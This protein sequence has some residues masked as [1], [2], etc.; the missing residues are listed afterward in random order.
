M[1]TGSLP[2]LSSYFTYVASP[3]P[4][5]FLSWVCFTDGETEA[6]KD[7]RTRSG[8]Y[9]ATGFRHTHLSDILSSYSI[10]ASKPS[11][12]WG[13]QS[14]LMKLYKQTQGFC[15][16]MHWKLTCVGPLRWR[17]EHSSLSLTWPWPPSQDKLRWNSKHAELWVHT[18]EFCATVNYWIFYKYH[19]AWK[20]LFSVW[21]ANACLLYLLKQSSCFN[22]KGS[23]KINDLNII[24]FDIAWDPFSFQEN[25][26]RQQGKSK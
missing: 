9:S 16:G 8:S 14:Q 6:Q 4:H 20:R 26:K 3:N 17:D 11:H 5:D 24:Y 7:E 10:L 2:A 23:N 12:W 21:I 13:L 1:T 15:M 22:F 19:L 25:L 18:R